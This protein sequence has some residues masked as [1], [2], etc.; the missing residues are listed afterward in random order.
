MPIVIFDS[1]ILSRW[2]TAAHGTLRPVFPAVNCGGERRAVHWVYWGM[3]F[4]GVDGRTEEPWGLFRVCSRTPNPWCMTPLGVDAEVPGGHEPV[5][6]QR[7]RGRPFQGSLPRS[8]Q[9][10]QEA[11]LPLGTCLFPLALSVAAAQGHPSV[12]SALDLAFSSCAL[13]AV[14]FTYLFTYFLLTYLFIY[15]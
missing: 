13:T 1:W 2:D 14:L 7:H 10:H 4:H 3:A 6:T 15:F 12:P 11:R 5:V 9:L 8:W